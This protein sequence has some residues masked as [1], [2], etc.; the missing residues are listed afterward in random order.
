MQCGHTS[1]DFDD[2]Q[3]GGGAA[4]Y[5]RDVLEQVG[6]FN[7]FLFSD[8]E[9][10]LCL[11]IRRAGYRIARLN[12]PIAYHYSDPAS[13][14]STLFARRSRNL[15]LGPGQALRLHLLSKFGVPYA[16]ERGFGLIPAAGIAAGIACAGIT[17]TN[18]DPRWAL[19]WIGAVLSL[20]G[21]D[22][23][24]R[25]SLHQAVFSMV[26]RILFAEGTLRGFLMKTPDS[27]RF[28]YMIE[29]IK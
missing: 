11:R 5:R 7:P 22:A 23:A 15:Y 29:V 19:A 18:R 25:H 2:V 6:S 27:A 21:A 28:P 12:Q 13:A 17:A 20:V 14:I 8:E 16:R 1:V 3:H 9:P 24:R 4:A 26:Q 10:E